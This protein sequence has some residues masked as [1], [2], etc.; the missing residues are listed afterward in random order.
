MHELPS[1]VGGRYEVLRL[2]DEG[3]HALV[4]LAQDA[5]LGRLVALKVL[6]PE[7]RGNAAL[8]SRLEQEVRL[9]AQLSHPNLVTLY[10]WLTDE[11]GQY[12]VLE[13]APGENLKAYVRRRGR[14]DPDEAERT[15]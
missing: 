10:D 6:K 1:L 7:H 13:Y 11:S 9:V 4:Y 5:R 2:I 3:G 14:L 15:P 12:A 8:A